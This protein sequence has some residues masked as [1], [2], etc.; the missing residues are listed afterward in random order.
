MV[1]AGDRTMVVAALCVCLLATLGASRLARAETATEGRAAA[2]LLWDEARAVWQQGD[3]AQAERLLRQSFERS[4]SGQAACDLGHVLRELGRSDEAAEWLE[5]CAAQ[6]DTD[7]EGQAQAAAEARALNDRSGRLQLLGADAGAAVLIDGRSEGRAPLDQEL[8]LAPGPH[9]LVLVDPAGVST[10][11]TVEVVPAE[12]TTV[13]L[14]PVPT[15]PAPPVRE[16]RVPRWAVWVM[17]SVALAATAASLATYGLDFAASSEWGTDAAE[18]AALMRLVSAVLGGVA[19][20]S[21]GVTLVLIP[22]AFDGRGARSSRGE[23][24]APQASSQGRR[25]W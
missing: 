4:P 19:G 16:R 8:A 14:R 11:R 1:R 24:G 20:T 10:R 6:P 3:A 13:E 2:L 21:L 23:D 9:E 15:P 18:Q 25:V 12:L 5:R 17:A 7:A 22:Y